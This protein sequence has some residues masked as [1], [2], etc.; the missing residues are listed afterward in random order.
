[1]KPHL[2]PHVPG[3]TEW[4]RFDNAVRK[5]LTILKEVFFLGG[6]PIESKAREEEDEEK[7]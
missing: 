3:D 1:M 5:A 6:S 7:T 4:E 2:A